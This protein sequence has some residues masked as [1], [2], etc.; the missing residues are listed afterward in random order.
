MFCTRVTHHCCHYDLFKGYASL[1]SLC[2]VPGLRIIVVLFQWQSWLMSFCSVIRSCIIVV[3]VFCFRVLVPLMSLCSVPGSCII[4]VL[5][6]CSMVMY[7]CCP[8]LHFQGH[9]SLMSLCSVPGSRIITVPMFCSRV[10]HHY[11]LYI[12]FQDHA[13]LL[14]LCSVPGLCI[15]AVFA[16]FVTV[17]GNVYAFLIIH[18][19]QLLSVV[20]RNSVH[21][22]NNHLWSVTKSCN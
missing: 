4:D 7:R 15:V 3:H 14:S 1:L 20:S 18:I 12:H 13:S 16:V 11:H 17:S 9:A 22:K 2:S 6:F 10:M 19:S 21:R 8:Y 5:M